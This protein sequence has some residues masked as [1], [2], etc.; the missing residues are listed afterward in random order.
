MDMYQTLGPILAAHDAFVCPTTAIA[1][2]SAEQCPLGT[3]VIDGRSVPAHRG[4]VM[5]Y[6]FNM[7]SPLPVLSVPSGRASD[8]V[9]IGL[10]IVGRPYDERLIFEIAHAF[11]VARG[12]WF[13]DEATSPPTPAGDA[14]PEQCAGSHV[15]GSSSQSREQ[16]AAIRA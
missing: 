9:P 2:V 5:T 10:Q 15:G 13:T 1:A 8:G 3:I 16:A 12:P 4:W 11:E 7:L 6:P 14:H